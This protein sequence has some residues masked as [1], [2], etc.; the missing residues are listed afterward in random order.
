MARSLLDAADE[1]PSGARS[2]REGS[3]GVALE[4]VRARAAANAARLPSSRSAQLVAGHVLAQGPNSQSPPTRRRRFSPALEEDALSS[5]ASSPAVGRGDVDL[6]RERRL[7][8]ELERPRT[9]ETRTPS[10]GRCW[11]PRSSGVRVISK[12]VSRR[13][14]EPTPQPPAL[15]AGRRRLA[16]RDH[17]ARAPP[18]RTRS[19]AQLAPDPAEPGSP[20]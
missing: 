10:A 19:E 6:A 1:R 2:E 9:K 18:F 14:R 5:Q 15:E 17:E 20:V 3:S 4:L 13:G 8:W 16:Q 12:A 7:E 11:R